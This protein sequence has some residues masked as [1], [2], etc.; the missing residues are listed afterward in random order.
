MALAA[1]ANLYGIGQARETAKGCEYIWN[2]NPAHDPLAKL[3]GL[4]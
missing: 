2:E 1:K 3:A 4:V